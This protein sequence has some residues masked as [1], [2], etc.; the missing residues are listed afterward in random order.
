MNARLLLLALGTF[1]IGT[2]GFLAAGVLPSVAASLGVTMSAAGQLMTVFSLAY[3]AAAPLLGAAA[4]RWNRKPVLVGALTLFAAANFASAL[5]PAYAAL[6]LTRV[7]AALGA[8]LFTPTA[9]PLQRC[10][11]RPNGAEGRWGS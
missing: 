2:D 10:S 4:G 3:A 8:A 1:A 5:A 6:L 9:R 7:A 11:C